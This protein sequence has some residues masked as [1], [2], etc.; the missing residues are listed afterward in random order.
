MPGQGTTNRATRALKAGGPP[1]A[2]TAGIGVGASGVAGNSIETKTDPVANTVAQ[3]VGVDP[4]LGTVLL[5]V[6]AILIL[7]VSL[8]VP[9]LFE[10]HHY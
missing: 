1:A 7:A 5:I 6:I 3:I 2:I 9:G 8:V 10:D 4:Q